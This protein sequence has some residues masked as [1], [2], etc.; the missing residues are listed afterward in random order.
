MSGRA[1][2]LADLARLV[3]PRARAESAPTDTASSPLPRRR[4]RGAEPAPCPPHD[5]R[6]DG[7]CRECG[8]NDWNW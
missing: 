2:T 3:R 1:R 5:R 6:P 4:L 7:S 8:D